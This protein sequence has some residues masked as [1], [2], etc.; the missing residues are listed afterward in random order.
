MPEQTLTDQDRQIVQILA[1]AGREFDR[2]RELLIT[3]DEPGVDQV[4]EAA[5]EEEKAD[6]KEGGALATVLDAVGAVA[7]SAGRVV[8]GSV[9]PRHD[10]WDS[11][12]LDE[13]IDWWVARFGTAAAA[14]AS[15]PN[16]GGRLGR[17]VGVG[18]L[19]AVA[20]QVLIVNAVA[21][22]MDA[23]DLATRV[24]V[25]ADI[26]FG[27]ELSPEAVRAAL[28][29]P[30]AQ[31]EENPAGED[32]E[33]NTGVFAFAGRTA[34]LIWRV[35]RRL[36][37]FRSGLEERQQGGFISRAI[38]NLPVVGA[39]GAFFNEKKGI[40]RAADKAREAFAA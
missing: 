37:G 25:A 32:P 8:T 17:A 27:R 22:E 36:W 7:Q 11:L 26:V 19:V 15:V 9:H 35:A 13:R 3:D 38:S 24:S 20:A 29:D 33:E 6:D 28:D 23:E 16:L 10:D 14:I 21:H 1:F 5:P 2:V 18:S 34:A 12:A 40:S 4:R 31:P 39:V 30:E